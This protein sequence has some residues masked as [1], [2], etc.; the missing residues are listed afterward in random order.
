MSFPLAKNATTMSAAAATSDAETL[1]SGAASRLPGSRRDELSEQRRDDE[2]LG[3]KNQPR[4]DAEA[5]IVLV[6]GKHAGDDAERD[7]LGRTAPRR[8]RGGRAATA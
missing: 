5:D 1:T 2:A 8:S 7:A 3:D 6:R 4:D